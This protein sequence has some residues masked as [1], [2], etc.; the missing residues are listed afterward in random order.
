MRRLAL[1]VCFFL[2]FLFFVP[3]QAFA[4]VWINEF[5]SNGSNDWIE[6][7]NDDDASVQ[8]EDFRIRD[9]SAT[10]KLDLTGQITGKGF[11]VFDW[12]TKLNNDGDAIRLLLRNDE[13]LVD[14]VVYGGTREID[15]PASGQTAGRQPNGGAAWVLFA[16]GSKG[17]SNAEAPVAPTATQVPVNTPT[18]TR[19]PT[20]TKIPTPT[21]VPSA[22][23]TTTID[24]GSETAQKA[25]LSVSSQGN[26]TL[27]KVFRISGVPTSILTIATI[28]AT[29]KPLPK[30]SRL[31]QKVLVKNASSSPSIAIIA[32]A[33]LFL[34]CG[35]LIFLKRSVWNKRQQL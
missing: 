24:S 28:S 29:P 3:L 21:K 25:V 9:S 14:Q 26:T 35:I 23:K 8:L 15:A 18:P 30:T 11:A 1:F 10:N 31:Q 20:P 2:T 19:E 5:S 13:S 27:E 34:A 33:I 4:K 16:T 17:S 22:P 12:G 32:G 7:Y 6:L